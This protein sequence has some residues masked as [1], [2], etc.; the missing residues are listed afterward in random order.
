MYQMQPEGEAMSDGFRERHAP[1]AD[2]G[3]LDDALALEPPSYDA[4]PTI[5]MGWVDSTIDEMNSG[6]ADAR[7]HTGF[8]L[9][10]GPLSHSIALGVERG[11]FDEPH[12][13]G[14]QAI[15]FLNY[16]RDPVRSIAGY[17][18]GDDEA[19]KAASKTWQITYLDPRMETAEPVTQFT[20]GMISHIM[21]DLALSLD[22]SQPPLSYYHD[23]TT[24]VGDKIAEITRQKSPALMPGHPLLR[25]VVIPGVIGGIAAMRA[26]AWRDFRSLEG[27]PPEE[28]EFKARLFDRRASVLNDLL[29]RVDGPTMWAAHLTERFPSWRR[30]PDEQKAA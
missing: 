20:A 21:G 6:L 26:L 29:L 7:M 16:W 24:K 17:L 4:D 3:R 23:Y 9:V 8:G 12:A 13:L 25:K 18:R 15:G 27:L 2:F 5:Q 10:Y 19:L 22:K 28:K 14:R 11:E 30:P 1:G